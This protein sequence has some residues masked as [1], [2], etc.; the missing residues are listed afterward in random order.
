M[1]VTIK[2]NCNSN[3]R[4]TED[5]ILFNAFSIALDGEEFEKFKKILDT[6]G[7][8]YPAAVLHWVIAR[9]IDAQLAEMEA[10][11]ALFNEGKE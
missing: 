8:P 10:I 11:D 1:T 4:V 9:G 5:K 3:V 2:R 6:P 7:K